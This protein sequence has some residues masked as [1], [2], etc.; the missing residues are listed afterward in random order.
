MSRYTRAILKH[1]SE[2]ACLDDC[3]VA[4]KSLYSFNRDKATG[5]SS[6]FVI[7][8]PL[9]KAVAKKDPTII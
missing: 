9:P 2:D 3:P 5:Q 4:E 6:H 7:K 1:Y 8:D